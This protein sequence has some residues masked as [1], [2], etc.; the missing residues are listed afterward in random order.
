MTGSTPYEDNDDRDRTYINEI[1]KHFQR[2]EAVDLV[3]IDL[4]KRQI[5]D[6]ITNLKRIA[7]QKYKAI[8]GRNTQDHQY[9]KQFSEKMNYID[10]FQLEY[11]LKTLQ[12]IIRTD[13]VLRPDDVLSEG[14]LDNIVLRYGGKRKTHKIKRSNSKSHRKRNKHG[15]QHL[16]RTGKK[17]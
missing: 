1:I 4:E 17:K 2:L 7:H 12:Q 14:D 3:I 16:T 5:L 15:K 10:G 11:E 9:L 6:K 8:Q 13:I